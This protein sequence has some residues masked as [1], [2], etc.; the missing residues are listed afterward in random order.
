T[1]DFKANVGDPAYISMDMGR[2]HIFDNQT[3]KTLV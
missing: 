2:I 1:M 3:G